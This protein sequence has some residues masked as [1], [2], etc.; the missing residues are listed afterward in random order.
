MGAKYSTNIYF[1]LRK[2]DFSKL[3]YHAK[4]FRK[5]VADL[6]TVLDD[7]GQSPESAWRAKILTK[8]ARDTSDALWKNLYEYETTL[9]SSQQSDVR[10]AQTACLKLH[11]DIKR[12]QKNLVMC[13]S[14]H[15]RQQQAEISM[16]GAVG[17]TGPE[18]ADIFDRKMREKELD[19]MN[20]SMHQV[21]DLYQELAGMVH[22]Q[23]EQIDQV[24]DDIVTAKAN[25]EAG[26]RSIHCA[27]DTLFCGAGGC[28][29]DDVANGF[30]RSISIGDDETFL[31]GSEM[32]CGD[33]YQTPIESI[34]KGIEAVKGFHRELVLVG[35]DILGNGNQDDED[36]NPPTV[37]SSSS[38]S[39]T[40]G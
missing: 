22:D 26:A 8:S 2:S 34:N 19:R 40:R 15:E 36:V 35:K 30:D 4:H 9:T 1:C 3:T 7:A 28:V 32:G 12:T 10:T 5:L 38:Q 23:Q 25:T 39:S 37:A 18:D 29:Q 20:Q 33:W 16:L 31:G 13:L 27:K 21:N 11:R 17:W 14:K 24:D 6:E